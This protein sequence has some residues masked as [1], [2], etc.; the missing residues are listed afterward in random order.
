MRKKISL[1]RII[2]INWVKGLII[3]VVF[4]NGESRVIDFH[5]VL[6]SLKIDD[7]SPAYILYEPDEFLKA[8]IQNNTLSWRNVEQ[9][10]TLK[11]KEKLKVPFEIG[12]DILLKYSHPEKSELSFGIGWLI[13]ESRINSGLTQQE[14][15]IRSGTTRNYI[16][17]IENDRSDFEL[18]TLKKIVET[19][20]GKQLEIVIK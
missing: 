6:K 13:R 7:K 5:K 17:R 10:I 18:A 8:E 12:A 14:L 1:P 19:G 15:A 11:N 9:Y 16:S 4:N 3:S 20:L 2:K